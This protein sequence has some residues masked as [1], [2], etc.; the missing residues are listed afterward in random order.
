MTKPGEWYSPLSGLGTAG[1][2]RYQK[3][4][5]LADAKVG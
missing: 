1:G 4:L 2:H 5:M 3:D